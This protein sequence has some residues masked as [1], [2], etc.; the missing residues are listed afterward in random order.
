MGLSNNHAIITPMNKQFI[1]F[2]SLFVI[3]ALVIFAL[4]RAI[5]E[6]VVRFLTHD[7]YI[8]EDF[9]RITYSQNPGVAFGLQI[10]QVVQLILIPALIVGGFY[11][12][13]QHLRLDSIFV[14]IV[15]G[16][17]AGGAISNFTDRILHTYVIDYLGI[18][19]WPVFNL[20]DVAITVGIL[21]LVLFYGKIK[22]V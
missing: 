7:I 17:I 12:V 19:F 10:P 4:D 6:V 3:S 21:L 18:W 11:L 5:K 14:Q 13:T 20:A 9:A 1:K 15:V 22:R 8:I 2:V 16:A